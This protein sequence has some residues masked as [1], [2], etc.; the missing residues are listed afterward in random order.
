M[1]GGLGYPKILGSDVVRRLTSWL[2][3]V[4]AVG[5]ILGASLLVSGPSAANDLEWRLGQVA[6]GDGFN[7][8][9]WEIGTLANRESQAVVNPPPPDQVDVVKQYFRLSADADRARSERDGAWAQQAV[10]GTSTRLGETQGRVDDL[11]VQLAALRPT[12]EATVSS[13]IEAEL[14]LQQMRDTLV[15]WHALP[16][17][18][19]LRPT[20][21]PGVFFQ[22]GQLPDLLVVSPRDRIALV[23]SVLIRPGLS[24]T[25]IDSLERGADGLD[26]SSVVTGIGGLAAYPSMLPDSSSPRDL[27]V[28]VAH[29]WTHHYLALQPLGQAYFVSYDM[30]VINETVADMVGHEVGGAVYET[31][32]PPGPP[33]VPAPRPATPATAAPPDF[34]TLM[35]QIRTTVEGYLAKHDVAGAEGYMRE[36]QV[37]LGRQGYYVRRL[38]TAYLSFFGSYSGSANPYEARLRLLRSH[39]GSLAAFLSEVSQINQ[40]ADLNRLLAQ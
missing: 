11:E 14:R 6:R 16:G 3:R 31:I 12:V 17:P 28:T 36:Q 27:L 23:G 32:Y 33:A 4:L 7:L 39:A 15:T 21:I 22:L 38:N 2:R 40:P 30:R 19:F 34:G 26:V 35:R 10:L 1:G 9:T 18:P 37:E 29:E 24:P 25:E 20:L 13:E 8:W 5:A